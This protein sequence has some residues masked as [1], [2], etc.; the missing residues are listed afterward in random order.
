MY[1]I[2]DLITSGV[3]AGVQNVVHSPCV[4]VSSGVGNEEA[5]GAGAPP[6]Q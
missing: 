2:I 4:L 3:C 1:T 5:P 6:C